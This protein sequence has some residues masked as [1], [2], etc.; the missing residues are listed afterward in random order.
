MTNLDEQTMKTTGPRFLL[1]QSLDQP[2]P[3]GTVGIV[4]SWPGVGKSAL[5]VQLAIDDLVNGRQV[6]HVSLDRPV[7]HV[8]IR[9]DEFLEEMC[10]VGM[11]EP[12]QRRHVAIERRRHIHSYL[13]GSFS[14]EKLASALD[15]LEKHMDFVPSMAIVDGFAQPEPTADQIR[16][17]STV[18]K[19]RDMNVWLSVAATRPTHPTAGH[20]LPSVAD[21]VADQA[22]ALALLSPCTDHICIELRTK[23]GTMNDALMMDPSSLLLKTLTKQA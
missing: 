22:D 8:R 20:E 21:H 7:D 5:L 12:E 15:F 4:A 16:A 18:A 1:E 14:T 17:L 2:M 3:P 19:D 9:Y 13:N 23:K 10:R 6:L 11:Y